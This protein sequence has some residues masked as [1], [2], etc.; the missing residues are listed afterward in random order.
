MRIRTSGKT[1]WLAA[2]VVVFAFSG[3]HH[4]VTPAA[5]PPAAPAPPPATPTVTLQASNTMI[6]SGQ[7]STLTWSSTNATALTIAPGVGTVAPEGTTSVSPTEST[8]YTITATGPG[9]SADA[10]ARVTVSAPPPPAPAAPS[11][12]IEQMFSSEVQDAYFD[13]DSADVRADART[14][15][16]KTADFIKAHPEIKVVIEGHCDERGSTE[17]NL[18]L[19]DRRA[20][21][22][23]N[24]LVS[25][26]ISADQLTTVSYGKERPFCTDHDETCWQQNRRGHFVLAK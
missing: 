23:K 18:A 12:T 25:L 15:L 5:A 2:L 8:T 11:M 14:A 17:Y 24:F 7:S 10:S 19:G 22:V 6:Q 21:A 9:G 4:N 20:A 3:C 16:A 1:A 13:L 26:G